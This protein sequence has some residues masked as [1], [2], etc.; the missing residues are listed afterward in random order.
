MNPLILWVLLNVG[1]L[2]SKIANLELFDLSGL[3]L[4]LIKDR[5]QQT[6]FKSFKWSYDLTIADRKH[7]GR[8]HWGLR[9]FSTGLAFTRWNW[10]S[11]FGPSG[12]SRLVFGWL[13]L[14]SFHFR[15]CLFITVGSLQLDFS[16][17]FRFYFF[18][19]SGLSF[20]GEPSSFP[21]FHILQ[22]AFH[23]LRDFS[24]LRI[25]LVICNRVRHLCHV[26]FMKDLTTVRDG[27]FPFIC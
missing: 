9:P 23:F 8:V 18:C 2:P 13:S 1:T 15:E 27:V 14:L 11:S 16:A 17:P 5:W 3:M 22:L 4:R 19:P 20:A 10:W 21:A 25:N 24:G 12:G 26:F 6:E 7:R